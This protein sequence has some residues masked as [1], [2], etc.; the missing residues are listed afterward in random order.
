[1]PL[2]DLAPPH[3][4]AIAP[5]Q[6][7]KPIS[8]LA[9]EMGLRD[10]DIVKLASNENPLGPSPKARAAIAAG[11]DEVARYPDGNGFAL[12][13]ALASKLGVNIAGV[14]LGNGSNDVL[15]LAARALLG[16]GTSAVYSEHAFAVYPLATQAVGATGIEV[17]ACAWGHDLAAM[18][19]AIRGNTR[20]VFIANPNNPTGT[21]LSAGELHEFLQS[22]PPTVAVVLDEAYGEF[23]DA[24]LRAP[25]V[26][27]LSE[28]PNLILTR[29]FSKAYGLAGLRVG[30]ALAHPDVADLLNRLRQPFNVNSL[31]LAAAAAALDDSE[32]LAR[33]KAVND[34]GMAQLLEGCE[35]LGLGHIPSH[36]NFVCIEVGG[37]AT[38]RENKDASVAT[39]VYQALLRKGVIVRP[40]A[41]YGLP[42]FLRVSI[43]LPDENARFLD[44]LG[45]I[46]EQA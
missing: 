8:E 29:T 27:W 23:L 6:P 32:F 41:N 31:G 4:R 21:L 45:E 9:R 33:A 46:Q 30:Y 25:S 24:R 20:V 26:S 42:A 37:H 13:S 44:A 43:G 39:R 17:P 5:Y 3:I 15:E 12:K 14:I 22:V 40:V 38:E 18:R 11:L 7:G 34:A 19:A 2:C 16:P 10:A 35:R 28:F 36:G 1:M